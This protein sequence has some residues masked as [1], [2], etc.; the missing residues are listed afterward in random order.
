MPRGFARTGLFVPGI[1]PPSV[2]PGE[3][4]LRISLSYGHT[5]AMIER[6]LGCDAL[7]RR[8]RIE[9]REHAVPF[10]RRQLAELS[11]HAF[12][13]AAMGADRLFERLCAAVV[14]VRGAIA[15]AP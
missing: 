8:Q 2:T 3:S 12:G 6:L 13:F 9:E 1:R 15:H 11:G 5:E 7:K 10:H 4:L 14:E